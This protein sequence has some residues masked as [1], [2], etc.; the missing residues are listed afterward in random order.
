MFELFVMPLVDFWA[1][2][3][4]ETDPEHLSQ[5]LSDLQEVLSKHFEMPVKWE[6]TLSDEESS[7][8]ADALDSECIYAL[9]ALAAWLEIHGSIE[10]FEVGDE[11]WLHPI[12]ETLDERLQNDQEVEHFPQI[13][14]SDDAD[15]V[16]FVPVDLPNVAILEDEEDD[17]EEINFSI[18]SLPG[19]QRELERIRLALGIEEGVEEELDSV[20]FDADQDPMALPRCACLVLMARVK[21]ALAKK[22]PL[23]LQ[24]GDGDEYSDEEEVEEGGEPEERD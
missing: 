6:E 16:A 14:N 19:L 3:A 8:E 9:R 2:Y 13:L 1:Q 17:E 18:G 23:M 7:V 24:L 15:V 11:P 10:G 4:D 12:L 20:V 22:M 5:V 21:E